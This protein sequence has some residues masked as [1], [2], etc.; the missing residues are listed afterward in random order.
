MAVKMLRQQVEHTRTSEAYIP[1]T[2]GIHF[3]NGYPDVEQVKHPRASG[4]CSPATAGIDFE[5]RC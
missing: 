2:A 5:I 3:E 4:A 1:A